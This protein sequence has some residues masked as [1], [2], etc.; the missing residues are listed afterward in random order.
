MTRSLVGRGG[1]ALLRL[2]THDVLYS[3]LALANAAADEKPPS[4]E[5]DP[6]VSFLLAQPEAVAALGYSVGGGDPGSEALV[7]A[8][9]IGLHH[10]VER[11][12]QRGVPPAPLPFGRLPLPERRCSSAVRI[13]NFCFL[14]SHCSCS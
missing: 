1:G 8:S 13:A 10:V 2:G 11:L 14:T 7:T 5:P 9:A 3:A 12:L 6:L 4:A